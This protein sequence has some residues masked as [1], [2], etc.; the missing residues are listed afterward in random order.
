MNRVSVIVPCYNREET[1]GP[2]MRSIIKQTCYDEILEII[3]VDDGS[4][5]NSKQVIREWE[6]R[7]GKL[8]YMYQENQGVSA[9]RNTGIEHS[10]GDFIAFL[11]ADD[12]WLQKRLESQ[13]C[14]VEKHPD[15]GLL[16][17]DVYTFGE[18]V[19]GRRRGYCNQYQYDD[20]NLLRRLFIENATILPSTTLVN[21]ECFQTVG[22]FDPSLP[23]GEDLDL[24][25]RIASEYPIQ[26][27]N[28]PLVLKRQR[29]DSLVADFERNAR[30]LL[31]VTDKIVDI[32]PRLGPLHTK[33]KA[34]VHGGLARNRAVSGERK[35]A[36]KSA[37]RA[38]NYDPYT[39]KHYATLVF[40]LLPFSAQQLQRVRKW[41][42]GAK[43]KIRRQTRS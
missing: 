34:K 7:C 42:Q 35:R 14:F 18:G 31:R 1:I 21:R 40:A 16:Y 12:V 19:K 4:E 23:Q 8:K 33:R 29:D 37:F 2:A 22:L 28:E 39:L 20:E 38:I 5:D 10:S 30:C 36:L 15:V 11:D 9:A 26:H 13:L 24:W 3:V 6:D 41:I 32:Y 25:L 43:R 27:I 17:T